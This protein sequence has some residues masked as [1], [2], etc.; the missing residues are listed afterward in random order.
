MKCA[1]GRYLTQHSRTVAKLNDLDGKQCFICMTK[2]LKISYEEILDQ[3]NG[4][5][6]CRECA[7]KKL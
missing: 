6:D 4:I 3:V 2:V 7:K 5:Q 1:C